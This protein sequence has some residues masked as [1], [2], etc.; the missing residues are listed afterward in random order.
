[1][2]Q[3]GTGKT[4]AFG[5]PLI[6]RID[7]S[8]R[9]TQALVL[10]PTRELGQ[11]IAKQLKIFSGNIPKL[12]VLPVYGGE[13]IHK[14]IS[15]LKKVPQI[16]IATPGRLIDLLK[17]K[18]VK[19]ERV[20]YVVL[21]EADE[22]LNM[23]FIEDINK[24][25]SYTPDEKLTWLFSATM[26]KG[27]RKI[28]DEYMDDPV[29]VKINSKNRVNVDIEHLYTIVK[30]SDKPEALMRFI[31]VSPNMR[32]VVFC[33]T[34]RDTQDL[35]EIL[36]KKKYKA[37]ALHGDLSQKQRDRVMGRFRDNDLQV[38]VA[39]D[40]AARGIDVSDLTHVFHF[41]LPDDDAYYT[42]RAGRTARAGK[43]GKSI[44]FISN[45]DHYKIRRLEKELRIVFRPLQIPKASDVQKIRLENWS[46]NLL[47][48]EGEKSIDPKIIKKV[49]K[50]FED[51]T[52]EQLIKK[53]IANELS[54]VEGDSSRDINQEQDTRGRG[55]GGDRKK[56]DY[57]RGRKGG[58]GNR[59]RGKGG[60]DSFKKRDDRKGKSK[61]KKG[62]KS[63]KWSKK[64]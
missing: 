26:P 53:L 15:A 40:V 9:C 8:E 60:K 55:G 35:A 54:A 46:K 34:K 5:L 7:T 64:R 62:G 1:M 51:L 20:E 16:I 28:V 37:D 44:A 19:L 30:R 6:D 22:M 52:K 49:N 59:K 32:S 48:I 43:K 12:K 61:S 14:Q 41:L 10:A 45:R 4:A 23:G 50:I 17:R 31:N 18:A 38:L 47:E 42:H 58:G 56:R 11:Q 25:L 13:P 39:T 57:G 63:S 33:R 21:D 2:A 24:I 29:E 27:V 36:L 3:T